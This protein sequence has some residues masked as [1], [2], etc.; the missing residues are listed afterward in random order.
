M[1]DFLIMLDNNEVAIAIY[2][3]AL[4]TEIELILE[5]ARLR[6]FFKVIVSAEH[7]T[8]GKPDPEGFLLALKQL[9]HD[10]ETAIEPAQCLVIEDSHWGLK[11][12]KAAGMKVLA[13][14]NTYD[15]DQLKLA[16]K[17]VDTLS[18]VNIEELRRLC[19]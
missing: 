12:A 6:D 7:V 16:D 18:E 11:A 4:L 10:S 1:R 15:A 13:V 2:S 14:T 9:N 5:E 19:P 8:K 3:G 17:V